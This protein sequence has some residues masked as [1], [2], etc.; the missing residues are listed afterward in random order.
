MTTYINRSHWLHTA[1]A[2]DPEAI[3]LPE[4]VEIAILGAGIMGCSL[5]YWLAR[6]GQRPLVIERNALPAGG[7][8]GRNGG[9]MV[10]GPSLGYHL[11]IQRLGRGAA[12][13]IMRATLVNRELL[14]DVLKREAIEAAYT[15]TGFLTIG[16]G[17]QEVEQLRAS[18]RAL[19]EDGFEGEWLERALAERQ[20]GTMLGP[21][22]AGAV[23]TPGDGQIHSA[24]YTFGMAEAALRYGAR[25]AFS[26]S[27]EK[28]TSGEA[29][30]GWHIHTPRGDVIADHLIITL[31]AWAGDLF[32]A[33][34]SLIAPTRGHIILTAPVNFNLT[35]WGANVGWDYGRQLE[36]GRLL[37][38]GQR[39]ARPD[40][41]VG[42]APLP[43]ENVSPVDM[44][45]V[46]ALT[47]MAP[48]LFPALANVPMVH[49]W[50]GAMAFTPDEQ[51]LVGPWPEKK[52]LWL[53]A[54]FSGHGMP[55]SQ[56]LPCALVA[57]LVGAEGPSIPAAFN[58]ARFL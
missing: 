25:F 10:A 34:R 41:D 53:L 20:L 5:A 18:V 1:P 15:R 21:D 27:T 29:G 50:T 8:T 4:R 17:A 55:F 52:G 54:G 28:V 40:R 49:Q 43:G 7:A 26:T 42:C 58:P 51:P 31:N 19:N 37:I 22:Y 30:G 57:Q 24:C 23:F 56:V 47:Q 6:Q 3:E 9:L 11:A 13:D 16:S 38:G 32:P 36:D 14:D 35:P 45:V 39:I 2:F 46:T 48:K 33:L 44:G 12:R